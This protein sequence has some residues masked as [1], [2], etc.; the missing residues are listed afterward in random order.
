[1]RHGI[2]IDIFHN[3]ISCLERCTWMINTLI[4]LGTILIL[5]SIMGCKKSET[6]PL[7]ENDLPLALPTPLYDSQTSVEQALQ[8][9]RSVRA[10]SHSP[11]SLDEVSQLLWAAQG[12]TNPDGKRTAPSAG[13]LYPLEIYLLA[14]N[15]TDLPVGIYHYKP[16]NHELIL[17]REGDIRQNMFEAALQQSAV[18][19]AAIVLVICAD[20]DRTTVKYGQRGIQYVHMEVGNVSQNVYLQV[21]SL[22]LGTVFIGAFHDDEVKAVLQIRDEENPLGLM[23]V[24]RKLPSGEA[25]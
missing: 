4:W 15:V 21:E 14:G 25:P 6:H 8:G 23:P 7:G 22:D 3:A 17:I 12:F 9:R 18:K 19:D 10:Y 16:R 2:A 5:F 20:Y 1:M 13:A 24:G 11:L